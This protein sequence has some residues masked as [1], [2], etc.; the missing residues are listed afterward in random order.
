MMKH[1]VYKGKEVAKGLIIEIGFI[2]GVICLFWGL[3]QIIMR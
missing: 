3:M 2:V 1:T